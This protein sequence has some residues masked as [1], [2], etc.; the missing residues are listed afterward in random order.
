MD[1]LEH[2]IMD[3]K[4]SLEREIASLR[5]EMRQGFAS[6]NERL[7]TQSS[8]LE[9]QGGIVQAGARWTSRMDNWAERVDV[10]LEAK[11]REI[12]DLR[13]RIARLERKSA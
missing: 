8:R 5:Q 6:V 4:E 11:D 7:D 3:L 2:L 12:A 9:R 10:A 1:N 13:E